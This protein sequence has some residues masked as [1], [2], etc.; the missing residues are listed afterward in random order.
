MWVPLLV[1]LLLVFNWKLTGVG[2]PNEV[3]AITSADLCKEMVE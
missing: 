1:F 3:T 2:G